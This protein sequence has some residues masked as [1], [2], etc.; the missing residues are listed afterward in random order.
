MGSDPALA[1]CVPAPSLE[2]ACHPALVPGAQPMFQGKRGLV[3]LETFWSLLLSV[4]SVIG[5]FLSV[6]LFHNS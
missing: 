1:S 2:A 3:W 6:G 4:F 5:I